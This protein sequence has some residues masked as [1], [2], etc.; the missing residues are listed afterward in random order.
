MLAMENDW[1]SF[2]GELA[3]LTHQ[4]GVLSMHVQ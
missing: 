1:T 3:W 4:G 2:G